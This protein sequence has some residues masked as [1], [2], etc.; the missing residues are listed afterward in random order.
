[1]WRG[2]V[3]IVTH[4]DFDGI[5]CAALFIRKFGVSTDIIYSTVQ[6]AKDFSDSNVSVDYTCDLPKIDNSINIDHH[7]TNFQNLKA[8]NRLSR[9][10]VVDPNAFSAT[11][12][13]YDYLVF[14]NDPIAEQVRTLGHLADRAL[15]P[16]EYKPLDIVLN[17]NAEDHSFLRA[18]SELLAKL[19]KG[20]LQTRW[21]EEK[22]ESVL[23][24]YEKTSEII[25][26]FFQLHPELPRIVIIDTRKTIPGNLAKEVFKP[27]FDRNVA[28]IALVYDK[29]IAEPLRVSFRVT[30][31]EQEKYDVSK[32]ATFFGGGGHRMAAACTPN[33][34]MVPEELINQ[35][36]TIRK[37]KDTIGYF[38]L[39]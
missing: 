9:N 19:G 17:M 2:T 32:I 26:A 28:V 30:K 5:C 20:I 13:V 36:K 21:L 27:L 7:R 4:T 38:G 15:L 31:A 14:E 24:I 25:S 23:A 10:D 37:T 1:M 8:M 16:S 33:P 22:H 29:S 3:R 34:E 35:L 18:L 12:L 6:Q 11:D 39:Q